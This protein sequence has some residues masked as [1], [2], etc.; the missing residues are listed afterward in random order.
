[1]S[2]LQ[3]LAIFLVLIATG[4]PI[5]QILRDGYGVRCII[6][7][8]S[9]VKGRFTSQSD[10]DL[11]VEGLAPDKFFTACDEINQASH[12]KV[13][14]KPLERLYSHFRRRVLTQGETLYESPG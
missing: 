11:A 2:L 4:E 7:F 10:I 6:L 9:L 13:D 1:M 14:L 8:G 12:F 5:V 3:V